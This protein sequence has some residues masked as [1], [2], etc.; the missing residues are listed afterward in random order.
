MNY[1]NFYELTERAKKYCALD[2][3]VSAERNCSFLP[4]RFDV[5]NKILRIVFSAANGN[6]KEMSE[7]YKLTDISKT[8][9][10]PYDTV[11]NW[12]IR[13]SN[14][15]SYVLRLIAF[16]IIKELIDDV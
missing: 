1:E 16:V 14:A 5:A 3:F 4:Q 11:Q 12:K 8:F 9:G 2:E 7:G 15:P 10:I 6:F 13:R